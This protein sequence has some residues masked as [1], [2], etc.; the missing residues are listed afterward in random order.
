MFGSIEYFPSH[1]HEAGIG[2]PADEKT[3]VIATGF[4]QMT[5]RPFNLIV[6][7]DDSDGYGS[8]LGRAIAES[9]FHHFADYN[10]NIGMGC[11]SFVDELPGDGFKRKPEKLKDIRRTSAMLLCG[12]RR[13]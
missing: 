1:P 10:W 3:R 2:I 5:G 11:P 6:A 13:H 4:S 8:R 7:L 12:W 9:S